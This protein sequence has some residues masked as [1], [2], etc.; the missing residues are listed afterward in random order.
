MP[1]TMSVAVTGLKEAQQLMKRY[2]A[3]APVI[4]GRA[5]QKA[6]ARLRDRVKSS[7]KI[8]VD[9]G[10]LRGSVS[11]RR[12][13]QLA[14]GVFVGVNYGKFVHE[15]TRRMKGRPFIQWTLRDGGM[16]DINAI[17]KRAVKSI[18]VSR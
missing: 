13:Q 18:P 3:V 10:R 6:G 5:V 9:T 7:S 12:I 15:G 8:P 14:A 11:K 1:V 17:I 4:M 2:P 16:K